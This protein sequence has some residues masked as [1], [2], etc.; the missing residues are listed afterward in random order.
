MLQTTAEEKKVATMLL[1]NRG[2]WQHNCSVLSAHQGEMIVARAPADVS[3]FD[4]REYVPCDLC[5]GFF[6]QAEMYRHNCPKAATGV[7][8]RVKAGKALMQMQQ[9]KM[10]KGMAS[11]LVGVQD[12]EIGRVAKSDELLLAWLEFQVKTGFWVQAKWRNQARAKMRLGARLLLELQKIFPGAGLREL[13][14]QANFNEI[15]EATKACALSSGGT[16]SHQVPLKLGHFINSLSKRM[17]SQALIDKDKEAA[18]AVLSFQDLMKN[19]WA[20]SVT[21]ACH[22]AI[23]EKKRNE[24]PCIPTKED[25]V[26]Y[27]NHCKNRLDDALQEFGKNKNAAN[28]R[29]LQKATMARIVQFNRRRGGDVSSV[30]LVDYEK[31][32]EQNISTTDEIFMSLT[33]EQQEAATSHKL[34][35]VNGKR[36]KNNFCILDAAMK[37]GLDMII[38]Y[39]EIAEIDP[40]NKYVFAIPNSKESTLNASKIRAEFA[41][42]ADVNKMVARGMRKYLATTLQVRYLFWLNVSIQYRYLFSRL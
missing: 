37:A 23:Q 34:L 12:D 35:V 41:A 6:K 1:R 8:P 31:A 4:F 19:D 30:T 16:E 5:F 14:H 2:N 15:A 24:V 33:K 21:T 9:S 26:K 42:E 7:K 22:F 40:N 3:T 20:T 11:V 13:L 36:N 18:E 27:A 28:Y 29:N 32:M 39:R 38:R 25:T 17:F 10:N